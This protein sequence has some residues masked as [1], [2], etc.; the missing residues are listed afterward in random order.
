[1]KVDERPLLTA[2]HDL[3]E[4]IPVQVARDDL[5]ANARIVV[6]EIG[7][8]LDRP[9]LATLQFE[10][11][12]DGGRAWFDIACRAVGPEPFSGDDVLET[13]A[14]HVNEVDGVELG[15]FDAVL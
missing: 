1:M 13:I 8:K 5:G 12:E 7:D 3:G 10:P 11:I 9:T 2:Y 6:D 4:L 15:E 14:I